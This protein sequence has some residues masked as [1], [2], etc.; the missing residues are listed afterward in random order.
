MMQR[1]ADQP[2]RTELSA[3]CAKLRALAILQKGL[4][5]AECAP[6]SRDDS[7]H[8]G[9]LHLRG[10]IAHQINLAIPHLPVHWHPATINRYAC[11]LPFERLHVFLLEESFETPFGLDSVFANYPYR[12]ALR[13]FR[14]QPVKVRRVSRNEPYARRIR[15]TIFRQPHDG[16]NK[17]HGFDRRPTGSA[18]HAAGRTVR[19]YNTVG[20]QFLALAAGFDLHSQPAGIGADSQETRVE[21]KAGSGLLRLPCQS[22]N[23]ARALNDEVRLRQRHLRRAPV[24]KQFESP[25][26]IDD[27]FARRSPHLT[28]EVIGDDQRARRGFE[29]RLRFQHTDPASATRHARRRKQSGCG[30]PDDDD[31][32]FAPAWPELIFHVPHGFCAPQWRAFPANQF[33]MDVTLKNLAASR[34]PL[35]LPGSR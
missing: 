30:T 19:A 11:A 34:P 1:A 25:N 14:N 7:S 16:L 12:R 4:R 24:G 28:S 10:R 27:A 21:E 22:G 35:S 8:G 32:P 31:F 3:Q 5:H 9:N 23:Q 6:K 18:R 15:W 20:M 33:T 2:V 17:R 26:F 29:L 13:G